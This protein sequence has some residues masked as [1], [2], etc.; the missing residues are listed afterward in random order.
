MNFLGL[1][2]NRV[3]LLL[4]IFLTVVTEL[5]AQKEFEFFVI[6]SYVS[7]KKPY[8]L[9]LMFFTGVPSKTKLIIDDKYEYS[10]SDELKEEHKIN[11]DISSLA[12]DSVYIPFVLIAVDSFGIEYKSEVYE[13]ELPELIKF[14]EGSTT[15]LFT[16]ICLGSILFLSPSP[17]IIYEGGN[18][19]ITLSKELP[20][21]SFYQSG[22]NYPVSYFGVEYSYTLGGETS[23]Y[24]RAG[25]KYLLQP[26][27]IKFLS[28]GVS[29][30]TDFVGFN[31]VSPEISLGLFTLYDQ[32]T[33]FAK[34]RYNLQPSSSSNN[35]SDFSI[36]LFSNFFSFNL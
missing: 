21:I 16:T 23:G 35:F 4:I 31:G 30:T 24:L 34:Y 7:V 12:F 19:Y 20:L 13:F 3:F 15:N 22:Y 27:V 28:L 29:Y 9:Q 11:V 8:K 17:G 26:G 25:Y 2:M 36:G 10:V 32:F 18:K 33:L 5:C 6:D 14:P 1:S